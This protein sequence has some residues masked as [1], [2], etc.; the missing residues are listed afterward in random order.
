MKLFRTISGVTMKNNLDF[1]EYN[2]ECPC[3]IDDIGQCYMQAM[4]NGHVNDPRYRS[5]CEDAC[6]VFFWVSRL[7]KSLVKYEL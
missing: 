5:C 4:D 7:E 3:Y 1:T 2:K 6:P